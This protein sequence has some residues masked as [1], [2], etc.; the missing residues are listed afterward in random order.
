MRAADFK[1]IDTPE[2]FCAA[3]PRDLVGNVSF[4][5]ALHG[6]LDRDTGAQAVYKAICLKQPQIAFDT[7]FFTLNPKKP[8]GMRN[9]PF[10]LRE[11]QREAVDALRWGIDNGRDVGIEKSREE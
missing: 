3:V 1:L 11:S 5:E 2:K 4:R 7:A 6:F 9:W 10:I 8:A